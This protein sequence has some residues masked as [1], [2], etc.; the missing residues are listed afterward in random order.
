MVKHVTKERGSRGVERE[1]SGV[2]PDLASERPRGIPRPLAV[3]GKQAIEAFHSAVREA[4]GREM[5][6]AGI[7]IV[8]MIERSV[9][10][11]IDPVERNGDD[12]FYSKL[13]IGVRAATRELQRESFVD[14]AR[15]FNAYVQPSLDEAAR[16]VGM[17]VPPINS[18]SARE[19]M[20]SKQRAIEALSGQL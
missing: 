2:K 12:H 10:T 1:R 19:F 14:L 18:E 20:T 11:L 5:D 15:N 3:R 4:K 16:A 13:L 8:E 9:N 17:E 7:V 6:K